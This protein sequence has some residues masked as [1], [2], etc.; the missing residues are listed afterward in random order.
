MQ[1]C[2]SKNSQTKFCDTNSVANFGI[3]NIVG[4]FGLFLSFIH[5]S[6]PQKGSMLKEVQTH[7]VSFYIAEIH[8]N[9][10]ERDSMSPKTELNYALCSQGGGVGDFNVRQLVSLIEC[11]RFDIDPPFGPPGTLFPSPDVVALSL[12]F[13]LFLACTGTPL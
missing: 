7:P 11:C 9:Q 3:H 2:I 4:C 1:W 6:V 8:K 5:H 10:N 13:L 12:L